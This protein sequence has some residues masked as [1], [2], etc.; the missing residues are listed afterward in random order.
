MAPIHCVDQVIVKKNDGKRLKTHPI[1]T[2]WSNQ[3]S[4]SWHPH[5]RRYLIIKSLLENLLTVIRTYYIAWKPNNLDIIFFRECAAFKLISANCSNFK[6][7]VLNF[8]RNWNISNRA[9]SQSLFLYC[10]LQ[11]LIVAS[12]DGVQWTIFLSGS[13]AAVFSEAATRATS[14]VCH[15]QFWTWS[16]LA[17]PIL[18]MTNFSND[19]F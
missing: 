11:K 3:S 8:W 7:A 6:F 10:A 12:V 14:S 16:I 18:A 9:V 2:H 19:Q 5:I 17:M 1:F 13:K 4:N 15:G